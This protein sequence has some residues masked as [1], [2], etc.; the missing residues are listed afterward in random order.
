MNAPTAILCCLA[1]AATQGII[2]GLV[3]R[4]AAKHFTEP[5]EVRTCRPGQDFTRLGVGRRLRFTLFPHRH[6][7]LPL[8]PRL[9]ATGALERIK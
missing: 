8:A 7:A 5:V 9:V 2:A 1:T 4:F 6:H 3:V